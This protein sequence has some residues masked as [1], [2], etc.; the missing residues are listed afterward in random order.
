MNATSTFGDMNDSV[1]SSPNKFL[2]VGF[3]GLLVG[4]TGAVTAPALSLAN[5]ISNVVDYC[6]TDGSAPGQLFLVPVETPTQVRALRELGDFVTVL[7][8][9]QTS[10]DPNVSRILQ[11]NWN[12]LF[13]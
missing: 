8:E 2:G 5:P 9:S 10:F 11:E 1:V 6:L 7:A 12:T 13:D 3:L 4:G